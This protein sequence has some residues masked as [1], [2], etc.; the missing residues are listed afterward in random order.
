MGRPPGGR[1]LIAFRDKVRRARGLDRRAHLVGRASLFFQHV[2]ILASFFNNVNGTIDVV[3]YVRLTIAN[4]ATI[5]SPSSQTVWE[6]G[7][8]IVALQVR[9]CTLSGGNQFFL[10]L[11]KDF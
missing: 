9:G 5:P 3:Y 1:L 4:N 10:R 11:G 6:L 8:G 2:S 7:D